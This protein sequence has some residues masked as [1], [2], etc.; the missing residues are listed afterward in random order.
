MAFI[1]IYFLVNFKYL[2]MLGYQCYSCDPLNCIQLS[3]SGI[4]SLSLP[5]PVYW[6]YLFPVFTILP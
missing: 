5:V 6:L 1:L 3:F 4:L 2:V